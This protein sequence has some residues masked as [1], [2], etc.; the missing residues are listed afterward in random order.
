MNTTN[1]NQLRFIICSCVCVFLYVSS[2]L[3]YSISSSSSTQLTIKKAEAGSRDAQFQLG[4]RYEK[5][6][7]VKRNSEKAI[8]WY[9]KAAQK[10]H[11]KA[12]DRLAMLYYK[13]KRYDKARFWLEKR[14]KAGNSEAQFLY[15]NTYRYGLGAKISNKSAKHW[16]NKA[17]KKDH[18]QAQYELGRMYRNGIGMKKNHD[19]ALKWFKKA[20][21]QG[22]R[23]AK[24]VVKKYQKQLAKKDPL[25][26]IKKL[27]NNNDIDAQ[28]NLGMSYWNGKSAKKNDKKAY[29]WTKKAAENDH[30]KAQYN[31]AMM[32]LQG[33]THIEKDLEKAKLWLIEASD[34]EHDAAD[35]KLNDLAKKNR[36]Q[37]QIDA[38]SHMIGKALL[39]DTEVQYELGMRYLL[40][41]KITADYQQAY[42]WLN[43]AAKSNHPL[44]LYQLGNR[45]LN[46]KYIAQ[47]IE[48]AVEYFAI[49]SKK[50]VGAA[51]TALFNM[52]Q[53]GFKQLI[54]A[55]LGDKVAQFEIASSYLQDDLDQKKKTRALTWLKK[56][57]AQNH[58]PA[59]LA[60]G[61][62]YEEGKLIPKN[63]EQAYDL[64]LTAAE[65]D[66]QEAQFRL[67][68]V[69]AQRK[70]ATNPAEIATSPEQKTEIKTSQQ[71]DKS[72]HFT[73]LP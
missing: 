1:R 67:G 24:A 52:S 46:A 71:D 55:T 63:I 58:I 5:G 29:Y 17:A 16:Y 70:S 65:M 30:S 64:Y 8:K 10:G 14:A 20:A 2:P 45:Y 42:Y 15:A 4:Y 47:D 6:K 34:N 38:F 60:L 62:I 31:L 26:K 23:D 44:A 36:E 73:V 53:H 27:A 21:K 48:K 54:D 22:H 43:E 57:S 39:G 11:V 35:K 3:V 37:S 41:Y 72:L 49:A 18:K 66:D 13:K 61:Q 32:Y 68:I 59:L 19:K 56:S 7:Q 50:N 51:K 9:R 40:G 69:S 25:T 28:F 12:Q 33:T